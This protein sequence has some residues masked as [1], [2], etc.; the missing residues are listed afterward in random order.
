MKN[1]NLP[2]NLKDKIY[3]IKVN[4]QND[5]SKIL[6][7]F[8]LSV[9]EQQLIITLMNNPKSF[10]GFYSI[11]SDHISKQEWNKSKA[12][13]IKRFQDELFDID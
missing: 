4:S 13:I 1:L 10:D 5:F 9:D 11:F 7:Y 3:Q 6:S 12:Q 2:A 8:P